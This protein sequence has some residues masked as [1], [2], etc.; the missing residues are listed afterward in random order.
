ML[1]S[2]RSAFG[3]TDSST[4]PIGFF[5]LGSDQ[6]SPSDQFASWLPYQSYLEE[7]QLFVNRDG[8]GFLLE[9]MP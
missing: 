8:I 1:A 4:E 6:E 9:I 2:L 7:E 5:G 3:S